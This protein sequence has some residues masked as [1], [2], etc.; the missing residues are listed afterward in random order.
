MFNFS[1]N[2]VS[3]KCIYYISVVVDYTAQYFFSSICCQF[4]IRIERYRIKLSKEAN[5]DLRSSLNFLRDEKVD[6]DWSG[7]YLQCPCML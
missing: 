6:A 7:V 5:L 2:L 4:G 1:L 3:D